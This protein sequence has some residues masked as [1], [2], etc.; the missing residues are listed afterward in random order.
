[1]VEYL[2]LAEVKKILKDIQETEEL[3]YIQKDVLEHVDKF[4]KVSAENA[5]EMKNR[6]IGMGLS[7]QRA[8]KIVDIMPR[9]MEELLSV[10]YKEVPEEKLLKEILNIV[11]EYVN[12]E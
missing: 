8:I 1:M 3:N 11:E 7:Q 5:I 12:S 9:S 10:F 2:T 6:L 4:A